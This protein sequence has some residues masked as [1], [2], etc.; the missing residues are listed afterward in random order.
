MSGKKRGLFKGLAW[1]AGVLVV[2]V[3]AVTIVASLFLG[4]IVKQGAEKLG[5]RFLGV[6]VQVEAV[7]VRPW[8]GTAEIHGVLVGNPEG[9]KTPSSF[10]LGSLTAEIDIGSLMSDI[11]VIRR[12]FITAPRVTYEVRGRKS[13]I[14]VLMA[15]LQPEQPADP[16]EDVP[17]EES[18][19]EGP[20][21]KVILEH[22]VFEE[23]RLSFN[24]ILTAGKSLST[25][26]PRIELRNVGSDVGGLRA[27]DLVF[28]VMRSIVVSVGKGVVEL[29][30][31]AVGKSADAVKALGKAGMGAAGAAAGSL[32]EGAGDVSGAGGDAARKAGEAGVKAVQGA[33]KA[34]AKAVEGAGEAG[35]KAVKDI[36]K[37]LGD[38]FG[39]GND[40]EKTEEE[41]ETTAE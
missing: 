23:G 21:R 35:A 34:G 31:Q 24:S 9:F 4:P 11:L 38:L 26:L 28:Q 15:N 27:V 30:G 41:K 36:G 22:F 33:G 6:P 32:A 20:S 29:S 12:L 8:S 5:P 17:E 14:N 19:K 7:K 25:P 13:N 3:V 10:E 18:D 1:A 2:L 40:D 16:V 37:A 39:G